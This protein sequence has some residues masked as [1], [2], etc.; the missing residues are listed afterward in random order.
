MQ[1]IFPWADFAKLKEY[2]LK[3]LHFYSRMDTSYQL[4]PGLQAYWHHLLHLS[5]IF[6]NLSNTA[7]T[8]NV[9]GRRDG[10]VGRTLILHESILG[11]IP[12]PHMVCKPHQEWLLRTDPEISPLSTTGLVWKQ[13]LRQHEFMS[14]RHWTSHS[15]RTMRAETHWNLESEPR[16]SRLKGLTDRRWLSASL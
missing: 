6:K 12:A 9:L 3:Y 2:F 7:I 8:G 1:K 13:K 11:L 5:C 10:T 14:C 4:C 15:M 16:I